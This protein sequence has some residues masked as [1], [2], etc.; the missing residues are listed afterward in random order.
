MAMISILR[1]VSGCAQRLAGIQTPG[2]RILEGIEGATENAASAS[3]P[4]ATRATR[5]TRVRQ[6]AQLLGVCWELALLA[7]RYAW[8]RYASICSRLHKQIRVRVASA[9]ARRPAA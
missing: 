8:L 2:K 5:P 6:D 1:E 4:I 3:L 9:V 7:F